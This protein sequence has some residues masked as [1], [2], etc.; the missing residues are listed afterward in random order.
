MQRSFDTHKAFSKFVRLD[1]KD[2]GDVSSS[3]KL[4]D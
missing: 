4:I 3:D 1:E 2:F